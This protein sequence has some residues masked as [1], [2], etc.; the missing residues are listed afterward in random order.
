VRGRGWARR[1]REFWFLKALIYLL[2][3][4]AGTILLFKLIVAPFL[5]T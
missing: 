1:R 2:M 4:A 3:A 5:S